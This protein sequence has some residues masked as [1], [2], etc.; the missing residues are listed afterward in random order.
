MA[1]KRIRINSFR[2]KNATGQIWTSLGRVFPG[3]VIELPEDE[4]NIIIRRGLVIETD[5]PATI[6]VG[7]GNLV[8]PHDVM[9][10]RAQQARQAAAEA[11]AVEAAAE[12]PVVD[13][14]S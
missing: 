8:T 4:A 5:D 2:G 12:T 1:T 14:L 10:M 6:T 11:A 7:R 9:I 3:Q 13:P